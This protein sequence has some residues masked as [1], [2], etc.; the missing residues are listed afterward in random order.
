M[1]SINV[2]YSPELENPPMAPECSINFS[3][4]AEV[5]G[6]SR[7]VRI[8]DGLN[9]VEEDDWENIQQREYARRLLNL[10]ALRIMEAAEVKENLDKVDLKVSDDVSITN[11]KIADAVKVVASTHDLQKLDT[12]LADEQRVPIRQAIARRINTLTGGD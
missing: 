8:R 12:W 7:T 9:K 2:F 5:T 10:G 11:L 3:F 1:T 6:E 4:I